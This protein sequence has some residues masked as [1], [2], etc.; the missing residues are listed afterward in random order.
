M[1]RSSNAEPLNSICTATTA[2]SRWPVNWGFPAKPLPDR[3]PFI[4]ALQRTLTARRPHYKR[5]LRTKG[6]EVKLRVRNLRKRPFETQI[7][8]AVWR[9]GSNALVDISF[10]APLAATSVYHCLRQSVQTG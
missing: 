9:V 4:D 10:S 7:T 1:M 6:G 8:E 3:F 2:S 5:K